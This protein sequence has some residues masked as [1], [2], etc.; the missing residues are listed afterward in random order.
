M[1]VK[2]RLLWPQ[3]EPERVSKVD[4]EGDVYRR[5]EIP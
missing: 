2:G 1:F 5:K 4:G 3:G